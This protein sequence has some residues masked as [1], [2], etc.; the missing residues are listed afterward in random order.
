MPKNHHRHLL[1]LSL[2]LFFSCTNPA[3]CL[4]RIENFDVDPEWEGINNQ[5]AVTPITVTQDFYWKPT[6]QSQGADSGEIGGQVWRAITPAYYGKVIEPMTFDD[7]LSASG[8]FRVPSIG[9]GSGVLIGWFNHQTMGWRPPSWLG[10]RLDDGR[11][12]LVEYNTQTNQAGGNRLPG[13]PALELGGVYHW[14]HQY[15]PAGASGQGEVRFTIDGPGLASTVE[16]V[17]ALAVGH[18]SQGANFD[19]FGIINLQRPGSYLRVFFDDLTINGEFFNFDQDP[20]WGGQGNAITYQD[21]N[22]PGVNR[23]G[24]SET[25]YAG[26]GGSGE[27]GGR[28]WRTEENNP[29]DAAAYG[30]DDIGLLSLENPLFASGKMTMTEGAPDSAAVLGWYNSSGRGWPPKNFLGVVI[31]GPSRVGHY[32]RPYYGTSQEGVS[33][34]GENGPVVRPDSIPHDWSIS[35]DPA[36]NGGNGQINVTLDDENKQLQ[37]SPGHKDIGAE[38]D[39]FGLFTLEFSG[40]QTSVFF[41]DIEY[42]VEGPIEETTFT[43]TPTSTGTLTPTFTFTRTPSPTIDCDFDGD[44]DCDGSDLIEVIRDQIKMIPETDSDFNDDGGE[45][46]QDLF[47]FALEWEP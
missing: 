45:D 42:T 3:V 47:L 29:A 26:G 19:R 14:T 10:F 38:F 6:N 21:T 2:A 9:G 30:D 23:F 36:G 32:F 15:D 43:A 13:D 18:K 39:R 12:V 22:L 33:K 8:Q 4:Q 35:Y 44:F 5:E 37:L 24:Y 25:Q 1:P 34:D 20:N 31:E 46:G 28:L 11:K 17:Q 16:F 27:M 7:P 41:D 40:A